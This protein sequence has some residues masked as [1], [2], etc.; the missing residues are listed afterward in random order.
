MQG[1]KKENTSGYHQDVLKLVR[2]VIYPRELEQLNENLR[3]KK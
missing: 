3:E 1:F 2:Q